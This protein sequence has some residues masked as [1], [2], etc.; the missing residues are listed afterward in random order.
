MTAY[1]ELQEAK[2]DM[3]VL[4]SSDVE[5]LDETKRKQNLREGLTNITDNAFTFFT[6]LELLCRNILTHGSLVQHGKYLFSNVKEQ[7]IKDKDLFELWSITLTKAI[8]SSEGENDCDIIETLS[9]LVQQ[10]VEY[11]EIF[12]AVVDLFIKVAF[13]QFRRDYLQFLKKEKGK[14]L[15]KKVMEKSKKSVKAFNM[16]F[17]TDDKSD[18]KTV[19]HLRLK[20][21]LIE[22]SNFLT[23][24]TFT[25]KDLLLLCKIY[26]V[27][28]SSSKKKNDISSVL[29]NVILNSDS[30]PCE[31]NES[32][33]SQLHV[34]E[35]VETVDLIQSDQSVQQSG[36]SL[37]LD[38]LIPGPSIVD[39]QT[40]G[41]STET[42]HSPSNTSATHTRI[43]DSCSEA[44]VLPPISKQSR[45]RK[46]VGKSKEK[47][48]EKERV[49]EKEREK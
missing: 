19:S 35:S 17:F 36:P 30:I 4:N 6:K 7:I 9:S 33:T 25:K 16:Q 44:S 34:S 49:R 14:A 29:S 47:E 46:L 37:I 1:V 12:N 2:L 21:E 26:N 5:S 41:P 8:S 31:V 15:R 38:M 23:E 40:P 27:T 3:L 22:N 11:I 42:P 48:R 10:C 32:D 43:T 20:S 13:S 18:G 28:V 45:R 39:D 24:K